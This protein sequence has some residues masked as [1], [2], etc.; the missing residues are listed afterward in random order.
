MRYMCIF[1]LNFFVLFNKLF[2]IEID[3]ETAKQ[4]AIYCRTVNREVIRTQIFLADNNIPFSYTD[5][6][7]LSELNYLF[8]ILNEYLKEK[9]DSLEKIN[10]EE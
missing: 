7:S 10:T 4:C 1:H 6:L 5:T 3:P 9:N 2:N 8:N